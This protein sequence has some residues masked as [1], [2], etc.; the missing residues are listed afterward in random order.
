MPLMVKTGALRAPG[1]NSICFV[2]QS[3]IDELAHS[4]TKDPVQFRLDLLGAPGKERSLKP[5]SPRSRTNRPKILPDHAAPAYDANR[6]RNVLQQVA[7]RS[8]WGNRTLP[9]GTALGVAFHYSF[10]GYFAHVAEVAVTP[11]TKSSEQNLDLRG[12]RQSDHQSQ[13]C[14][15]T[16][17][18]RSDGWPQ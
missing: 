3:F 1:A 4:A 15:S 2:I 17:P 9:K 5:R 13:R 16:S 18:R 14:R 8:G 7:E 11:A 6:M 10:Q 12:C